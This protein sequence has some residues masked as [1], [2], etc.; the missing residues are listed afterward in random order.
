MA[1]SDCANWIYKNIEINDIAEVWSLY[2]AVIS[3]RN[4]NHLYSA[5]RKGSM[6][7]VQYSNQNEPLIIAS[8]EAKSAFIK[9]LEYPYL[10]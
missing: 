8:D 9:I 1:T 10:E 6:P 5:T 2:Q 4:Y 7:Y 3:E